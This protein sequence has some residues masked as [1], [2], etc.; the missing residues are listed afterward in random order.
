MEIIDGGGRI[1]KKLAFL[2][3]VA[4]LLTALYAGAALAAPGNYPPDTSS[5]FWHLGVY[6]RV[7]THNNFLM[8]NPRAMDGV[9]PFR[10]NGIHPIVNANLTGAIPGDFNR[11]IT[12]QKVHT[13]FQINTN[14]CA[15]CHMT[16]TAP[17]DSL[18]FRA[19]G[20]YAVCASCHDGTGIPF[21]NV[22]IPSQ[23][24]VEE[25]NVGRTVDTNT[26]IFSQTR[27]SG[28]F[29]VD[30]GMNAS[31]HLP[32]GDMR[33]SSAPGGNRVLA[34]ETTG[35]TGSWTRPLDCASCHAPHGSY[36]YRLLHFNPNNIMGRNP[37]NGGL[38]ENGLHVTQ[39]VYGNVYA[40]LRAHRA[41]DPLNHLQGPWLAGNDDAFF[42]I[43]NVTTPSVN[44]SVY[45]NIRYRN[46]EFG[47]KDGFTLGTGPIPAL[48][49][50][51]VDIARAL[52]VSAPHTEVTAVGTP[53]AGQVATFQGD[54]VFQTGRRVV[55]RDGLNYNF[56]CAAC[57]T[58]YMPELTERNQ[59]TADAVYRTG[60]YS[61]A[62]RHITFGAETRFGTMEVI[63]DSGGVGRMICVSCHF[64]H[65]SDAWIKKTADEVVIGTNGLTAIRLP[66]DVAT[67]EDVNP[68]SAIKRYVNQS[69][70]WKCHANVRA[71][72][73]M[74]QD[75]YWNLVEAMNPGGFGIP[76]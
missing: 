73:F 40:R 20:T 4:L 41:G 72:S 16:H 13:N 7:Y 67:R 50:L 6:S 59:T 37:A 11:A 46:G 35:R 14:S 52:V 33:I 9:V 76:W 23:I 34:S 26:S 65:G 15:S 74:N 51:R 71:S 38:R 49:N 8:L 56:F 32:T 39:V 48:A 75:G 21:L 18:L 17:G 69:V 45:F 61:K 29:G 47:L 70:C 53:F 19:G 12:G 66:A 58:D 68:S 31:V 64:V 57:H 2:L 25:R 60:I 42:W 22:F 5:Q 62:H 55:Y 54:V 36:S 63:A 1:L 43:Y 3:A 28:T 27:V 30:P 44:L 10:Y 24:T